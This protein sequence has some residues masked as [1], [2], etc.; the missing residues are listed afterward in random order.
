MELYENDDFIKRIREHLNMVWKETP[1]ERSKIV[2]SIKDGIAD[3]EGRT[4]YRKVDWNKRANQNLLK[5]WIRY[6]L[7]QALEYFENNF[8]SE[9]I[10]FII[11]NDSEV[12]A[13]LKK[14][15]ND[16]KKN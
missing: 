13:K 5:N 16:G 10:N 11:E 6:D 9:L 1:V 15:G 2:E 8:H 7:S 14:E 3:L 12:Y 4:E